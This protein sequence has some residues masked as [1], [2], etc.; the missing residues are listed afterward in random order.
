MLA[1]LKNT[2]SSYYAPLMQKELFQVSHVLYEGLSYGFVLRDQNVCLI[3]S[4]NFILYSIWINYWI[5]F[6]W[7]FAS[8]PA[9]NWHIL[10]TFP[11]QSAT[12]HWR[13]FEHDGVS[14]H[15]PHDCFL[16]RLFRRRSK[17]NQSSA[18]LVLCEEFTGTGEF[19]TQRASYAENVSIWWHH[20]DYMSD[21]YHGVTRAK[22][23]FLTLTNVMMSSSQFRKPRNW[24]KTIWW[25]SYLHNGIPCTSKMMYVLY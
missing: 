22:T 24:D 5:V 1:Y 10:S 16:S 4:T 23:W 20:H 19:P 21:S 11:F 2:R 15:L 7:S 17:K 18:S 9:W 8:Q 14:N 6:S 12:L 3:V 13:Y 25:P